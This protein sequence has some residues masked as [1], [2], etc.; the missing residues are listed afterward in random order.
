MQSLHLWKMILKLKKKN[1]KK[2]M[3]LLFLKKKN[4]PYLLNDPH[5]NTFWYSQCILKPHPTENHPWQFNRNNKM[6]QL[7]SVVMLRV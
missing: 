7:E 6:L 2:K 1:K 4:F 5:K 3:I